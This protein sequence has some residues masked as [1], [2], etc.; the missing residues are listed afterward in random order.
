MIITM[1]EE[2]QVIEED[3]IKAIGQSYSQELLTCSYVR[4]SIALYFALWD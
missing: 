4:T 1:D 3:K 2:Q